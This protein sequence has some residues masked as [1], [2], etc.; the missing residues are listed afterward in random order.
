MWSNTIQNCS[1]FRK[2]S[3]DY[4][5]EKN[6]LTPNGYVRIQRILHL[7]WDS[8]DQPPPDSYTDMGRWRIAHQL[9][10][11]LF[12]EGLPIPI[13]CTTTPSPASAKL[14]FVRAGHRRI[15]GLICGRFLTNSLRTTCWRLILKFLNLWNILE[16]LSGFKMLLVRRQYLSIIHSSWLPISNSGLAQSSPD[17]FL[18]DLPLKPFNALDFSWKIQ[19]SCWVFSE[20]SCWESSK[21][22]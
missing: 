18:P 20:K 21:N 11:E 7:L 15:K 14:I 6:L 9:L 16:Y 13:R 3:I 8:S 5:N 12:T 22:T 1:K 10:T 19:E 17:L 4:Q 2:K